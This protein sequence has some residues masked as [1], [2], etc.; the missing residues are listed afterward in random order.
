MDQIIKPPLARIATNIQNSLVIVQIANP[1]A[2]YH[3]TSTIAQGFLSTPISP[4][5]KTRQTKITQLYAWGSTNELLIPYLNPG[6]Q[7]ETPHPLD[8]Q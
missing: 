7:I 4:R 2:L 3:H 1:E 8:L 6:I 5:K